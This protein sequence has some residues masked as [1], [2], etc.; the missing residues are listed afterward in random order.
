MRQ[1]IQK[2]IR[3]EGELLIDPDFFITLKHKFP[4]ISHVDIQLQRGY[5]QTE[6]SRFRYNVVLH[7]DRVD[8]PVTEPQWLDWQT[9]QLNLETLEKI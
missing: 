7:L 8:I 3:T 1:H 5:A 4:R 2:S 6:M 9:E